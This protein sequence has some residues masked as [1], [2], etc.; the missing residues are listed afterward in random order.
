M[1]QLQKKL[2][3]ANVSTT[4]VIGIPADWVESAGFAWLGYCQ[5]HGI[6]S[7]LPSV[8]GATKPVVLGE[9]FKPE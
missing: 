7:N 1:Q 3:N 5:V 8:T 6:P 4:D 2:V 9:V